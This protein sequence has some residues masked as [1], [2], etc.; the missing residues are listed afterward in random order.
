MSIYTSRTYWMGLAER[1][2]KTAAQTLLSVLTVGATI[3]SMDWEQALG[4][5]AGAVVLSILTSIADPQRADTAVA[6]GT[7]RHA[8]EG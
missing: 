6:T 7:P 3:W 5:A 1:A 2:I 8:A 4:I